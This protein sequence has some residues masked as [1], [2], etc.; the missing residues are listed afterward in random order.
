MNRN[1]QEP[2]DGGPDLDTI[3]GRQAPQK[4]TEESRIVEGT[5]P[6][7]GDPTGEDPFVAGSPENEEGNPDELVTETSTA[8]GAGPSYEQNQGDAHNT[9]GGGTDPGND[10][11]HSDN[12]ST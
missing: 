11:S 8:I 10:R 1:H 12:K 7:S 5:K 4:E 3:R 2:L 9:S 6:S